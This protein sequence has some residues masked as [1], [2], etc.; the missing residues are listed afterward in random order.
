MESLPTSNYFYLLGVKLA[1]ADAQVAAVPTSNYKSRQEPTSDSPAGTSLEPA[2]SSRQ[3]GASQPPLPG[4][5][6]D[7]GAKDSGNWIDTSATIA[8]PAK[9]SPVGLQ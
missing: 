6:D 3:T 9:N 1:W 5:E 7:P 4:G 8:D 2:G